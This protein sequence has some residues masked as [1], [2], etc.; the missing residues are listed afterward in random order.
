MAKIDKD[1]SNN[2]DPNNSLNDSMNDDE[3]NS[4]SNMSYYLNDK[5]NNLNS[6][7]GNNPQTQAG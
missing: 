6:L 4:T 7:G 2:G 1:V 3:V 5:D